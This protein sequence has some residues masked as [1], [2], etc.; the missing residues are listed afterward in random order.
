MIYLDKSIS[1]IYNLDAGSKGGVSKSSD[2][3]YDETNFKISFSWNYSVSIEYILILITWSNS[4]NS[5]K[6]FFPYVTDNI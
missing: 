6:F 5:M 4:F 1:Y 2:G 3:F